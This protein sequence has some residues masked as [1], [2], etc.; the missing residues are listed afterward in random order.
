MIRRVLLLFALV[1]TCTAMF[2]ASESL[3]QLKARAASAK[4]Q[5]QPKI[6]VQIAKLELKNVEQLYKD[7]NAEQGP[8]ALGDLASACVNAAQSA[9]STRKHLKKTEIELRKISDRLQQ[10]RTSV[11]FDSRPPFEAAVDRIEHSRT[12]LLNAMF[13]K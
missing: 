5:D 9:V 2:A 3:D 7:G 12:D 13:K 1:A 8:A 6:Y 11:D 10:M 4:P